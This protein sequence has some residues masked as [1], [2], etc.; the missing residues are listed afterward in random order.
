VAGL[1]VMG[2]KLGIP[3]TVYILIDNITPEE[4]INELITECLGYDSAYKETAYLNE[5]IEAYPD[6]KYF[7]SY[8]VCSRYQDEV[9]HVLFG[10][11]ATG[12]N[13]RVITAYYPD[14][15]KWEPNLKTRRTIL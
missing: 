9:F 15:H 10:V 7:P 3:G 8:L 14:R 12:D 13:V 11:D 5:I 6:D 2:D 4:Y 1:R